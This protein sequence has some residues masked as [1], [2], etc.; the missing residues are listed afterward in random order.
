MNGAGSNAVKK[1]I[2]ETLV[3]RIIPGVTT[4]TTNRETAIRAKEDHSTAAELG[5]R[6]RMTISVNVGK[7]IARPI[8]R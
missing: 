7:V 1:L 3:L 6:S 8:S 5:K 2:D 4:I